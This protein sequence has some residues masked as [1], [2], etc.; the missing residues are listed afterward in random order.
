M[1]LRFSISNKI[2]W[3]PNWNEITT[4]TDISMSSSLRSV[5]YIL[6]TQIS[7]VVSLNKSAHFHLMGCT[8]QHC[9]ISTLDNGCNLRQINTLYGRHSDTNQHLVPATDKPKLSTRNTATRWHMSSLTG[10]YTATA[11]WLPVAGPVLANHGW[12]IR[13]GWLRQK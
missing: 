13:A 11:W 7:L 8:S 4:L 10:V 6:I 3:I 5:M 2:N 9:S 1:K 12:C